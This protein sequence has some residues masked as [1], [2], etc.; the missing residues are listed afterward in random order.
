MTTTTPPSDLANLDVSDL[1]L[2]K[3]GPPHE[4]FRQLRHEEPLHWS[5]LADFPT[6][7]GFW[8]VVRFEDI[9]T[10]GRDHE[11][12]S[13][14]RS[15]IL[16]DKLASEPG[17]PDPMDVAANMMITQDPP[18]HDRLKALVAGHWYLAE[19]ADDLRKEA[20]AAQVPPR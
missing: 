3:D 5:E 11:T 14:N 16:V 20:T 13:S 2:W 9:A 10:V 4:V 7:G 15:I 19:D 18:R 8:S 1:D 12:F 6:E 17:A